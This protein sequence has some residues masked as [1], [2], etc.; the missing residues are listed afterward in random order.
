MSLENL[1]RQMML[2]LIF[3]TVLLV[4]GVAPIDVA[5]AGNNGFGIQ[6]SIDPPKRLSTH[7][8]STPGAE[9][10]PQANAGCLLAPKC[11]A[12]GMTFS[13]CDAQAAYCACTNPNLAA[14]ASQTVLRITQ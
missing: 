3:A 4:S 14:C 7:R 9:Q 13:G 1:W 10:L 11:A 5:F 6:L 8:P 2:R 12:M